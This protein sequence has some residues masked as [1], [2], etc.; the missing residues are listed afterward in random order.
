MQVYL[1]LQVKVWFQYE[2]K[3]IIIIYI[4]IYIFILNNLI[5]YCMDTNILFLKTHWDIFI[6]PIIHVLGET[7]LNN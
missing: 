7:E 5:V 1:D 3:C 4:Y 6:V 2:L